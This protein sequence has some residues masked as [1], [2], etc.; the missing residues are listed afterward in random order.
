MSQL[1]IHL[2]AHL[3]ERL[4]RHILGDAESPEHAVQ[5][6]T[7]AVVPVHAVDDDSPAFGKDIFPPSLRV[8]APPP[9]GNI[10]AAACSAFGGR[11]NCFFFFRSPLLVL[12]LSSCGSRSAAVALAQS[13]K[14]SAAAEEAPSWFWSLSLVA[15]FGVAVLRT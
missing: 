3:F 12:A 1:I 2:R 11:V 15:P 14:C 7:G 4:Q 8:P 13:R 6:N 10:K 5:H 9:P